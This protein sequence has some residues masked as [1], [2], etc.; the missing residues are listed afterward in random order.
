MASNGL[1]LDFIILHYALR[2]KIYT[3]DVVRELTSEYLDPKVQLFWTVVAKNFT[4]PLV[5]EVLSLPALLD[6]CDRNK[7]SDQKDRFKVIYEKATALKLDDKEPAAADFKYYLQQIKRRR[8]IDVAKSKIQ[9]LI[10]TIKATPDN[11]EVVNNIFKAAVTEISSINRFQVYDEGTVG[12]DVLNM[13]EEYKAIES[14]PTP[15]RGIMCGFPSWDNRSNGLHP[16][17]LTLIAGME[18]SGKSLLMMNWAVNAWLGMNVNIDVGSMRSKD[19]SAT[20]TIYPDGANVLYFTL[21]MPRSNKGEYT[22][23]SYLN[24]RI[25]SCVSELPL[26]DIKAGTLRPEEKQRL[27]DC[28]NFIRHY[29]EHHHKFY[30]VDIPRGATVEDIETKYLEVKE[31][32]G[33]VDVVFIDY[34][35]IMAGEDDSDWQAQGHIAAGLHEF[36]RIYHVPV[37]TAVQINRPKGNKGQSL[38]DQFYNTNRLARS[39]QISQNAN[40]VLMIETRDKEWGRPE[41][42]ITIAKMRDGERARLCFHKHFECMRVYDGKEP[43]DNDSIVAEDIESNFDDLEGGSD[44]AL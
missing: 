41:M 29:E 37:V 44:E 40:N 43:G 21:E 32:I 22:Q 26:N 17:E 10:D 3:L 4:D 25:L 6:Y 7:L 24:K 35:G 18:G 16:G 1:E 8:N 11:T 9:E 36:A 5:R 33:R 14:D 20:D 15:Y 2:D 42:Y 27:I 12:E 30:I 23:G 13:V 39:A 19:F 28:A 31:K 38:D 34:I